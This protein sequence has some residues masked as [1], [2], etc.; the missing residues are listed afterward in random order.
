MRPPFFMARIPRHTVDHILATADIVEVIGDYLPLKKKGQNYWAHS[1][2]KQEKT[3]SF[4]VSPQKQIFKDFSSG[5]GG[6][7]IK[8]LIEVEQM[9]YPEALRHLAKRYGISI[10]EENTTPEQ[11]EAE[12]HR[13]KLLAI[14]KWAAGWYHQQLFT[15]AGQ[16]EAGHYLE[17][18]GFDAEIIARFQVGY[19]PTGWTALTDAAQQHGHKLDDLV[20]LG[21]VV[22]KEDTG[23]T[24]DRYRG[25][26]MFPLHDASG[27][28]IGFAGRVLEQD[29]KAAKYVNSPESVVYDKSRF[30]YG[31][32]FSKLALRDTS[33]A[34]L[35]EG[36]TDVI[37]LHAS[38]LKTAVAS[39]GTAFT[40][41]QAQLLARYAKRVVL[42]Y[43]GDAAGVKAAMRAV[44]ILVPQGLGV[45][46]LRLPPEHDPDSFVQANGAAGLREYATEHAQD[47]IA[48]QLDVLRDG[49]SLEDPELK[50]ELVRA[51]AEALLLI[52]DDV[53]RDLYTQ[54]A[55]K[56][57]EVS[58]ALVQNAMQQVRAR[59]EQRQRTRERIQ[60]LEAGESSQLVPTAAATQAPVLAKKQ[61]KTPLY[62][63]EYELL[64]LY[65]SRFEEE[66][67]EA[68]TPEHP[69]PLTVRFAE[70]ALH[71][72][73]DMRFHATVLETIRT[74]CV[75]AA[76][77]GKGLPFQE[78][79]GKAASEVKD[80]VLALTEDPH[81]LADRWKERNGHVHQPDAN[82]AT[83]WEHAYCY[84]QYHHIERVL[85]E[86]RERLKRATEPE[87]IRHILETEQK[88][89]AQ[90]KVLEERLGLVIGPTVHAGPAS[91]SGGAG[92]QTD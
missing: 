50:T 6:D 13:A 81:E 15:E 53:Q 9:T 67:T 21:L 3:P 69:E 92:P 84:Y 80:I 77:A 2:F 26:L 7:V 16:R 1:P 12:A 52:P 48:Y 72:M 89:R 28:V 8:F 88:L 44:Q 57:L 47:F 71:D 54:H 91:S 23:R 11:S 56:H 24:Y 68:A 58:S 61:P 66:V 18:R 33:E 31:L 34:F 49:R 14:N 25:R 76:A 45:K 70:W 73:Q 5:L 85:T 86:N 90:R 35:V 4:S 87:A 10:E 62:A 36:Y 41:A 55:A 74:I 22:R 42:L 78:L 59:E 75:E 40:E 29:A 63:Q 51:A 19:N 30:L 82:L 37:S 43:D 20:E 65:L 38:G 64:R 60:R 79:V 46:V 83:A 17:G 39:S 27:Q 32:Y